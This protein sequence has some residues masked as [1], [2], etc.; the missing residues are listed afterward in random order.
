MEHL[1]IGNNGLQALNTLFGWVVIGSCDNVQDTTMTHQALHAQLDLDSLVRTFMEM[2]NI[3]PSKSTIDAC[4]P[5]EQ[6]F[7]ASHKRNSEGVYI[8]EY[9]FKA[10]APPHHNSMLTQAIKRFASQEG[11]FRRYP[12]LRNQYVD[13]MKNYF[14]RGQMEEIHLDKESKSLDKCVYLAHHAVMKPESTTTKCRVVFDG[15][16]KDD[17]GFSLNDRMHMDP[18]IQ[19]DLF[20]V[21]LRF[22]QHC[23][24]EDVSRH[25]SIKVTYGFATY[26]MA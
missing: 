1:N 14:E 15:S 10:D 25:S 9:P 18:P 2:H 23:Y 13:F 19:R 16:V 26:S 5:T 12:N 22:R 20:G 6:H 11:K 24:V 17:T 3:N 4:D 8:V 21:C 7:L